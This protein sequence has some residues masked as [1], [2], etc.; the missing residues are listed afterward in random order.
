MSTIFKITQSPSTS[1]EKLKKRAVEELN[2]FF[3]TNWSSK[4][5]N[6]FLIDD[7][8][9]LD[10]LSEFKTK[11]W[12]VGFYMSR[13]SIGLINPKNLESES[14]H[15]YSEENYFKLIKHEI[16][17][18]Y[19]GAIFGTSSFR[20]IEEGV[21]VYVSWQYEKVTKFKNLFNDKNYYVESG[22]A[23]KLLA[24]KFGE[25]SIYEFLKKQ[26]GCETQ[27]E[28][29][30]AFEKVYGNRPTLEFFNHLLS[31]I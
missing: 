17:H 2:Q 24:D 16:C 26:S 28:M 22:Y 27:K 29:E 1:I 13:N 19:L 10:V 23:F 18:V 8:K 9:T 5:I 25:D 20:W 31:E 4:D 11:A 12:M 6:I 30:K 14:I 15:K 21:C 7:R 3:S